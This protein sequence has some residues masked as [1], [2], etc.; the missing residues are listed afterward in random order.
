MT[1]RISFDSDAPERDVRSLG[2]W[3]RNEP[4][5]RQHARI[6]L[7]NAQPEPG[8][9]G[10]ALEAI[11]LAVDSGFSLAN[12]ALAISAWRRSRVTSPP[13]V[14]NGTVVLDSTKIDAEEIAR[15]LRAGAVANEMGGA[16]D[17]ASQS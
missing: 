1:I 11:Q 7:E 5:I 8:R 2:D 3:L 14:V 4:A 9:M 12:L 10:T 6:T 16:E 17:G 15:E 13:I